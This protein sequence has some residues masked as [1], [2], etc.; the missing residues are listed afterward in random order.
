MKQ[1]IENILISEEE[2]QKKVK[3]PGRDSD[4]R[5]Q[6]QVSAGNRC[7]KRSHAVYG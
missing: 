1:D 3:E 2:I 7:V 4:R 5:V 6:R